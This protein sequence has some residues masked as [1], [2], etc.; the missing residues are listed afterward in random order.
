MPI[1]VANL[2]AL[3]Q[4]LF[5][6]EVIRKVGSQAAATRPTCVVDHH[7]GDFWVI[8]S[9]KPSAGRQLEVDSVC[10]QSELCD[11]KRRFENCMVLQIAAHEPE[12][13]AFSWSPSSF[14]PAPKTDAPAG[15]PQ[16]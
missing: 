12:T 11:R 2:V 14:P 9:N 3:P 7:G 15:F 8:T 13:T 1:E 4:Y 6:R 10:Y 16:R 5:R